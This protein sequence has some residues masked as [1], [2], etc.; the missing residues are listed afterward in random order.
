MIRA[1]IH[2]GL[3][4]LLFTIA[5][6]AV[7]QQRGGGQPGGTL[8]GKV[9]DSA[10]G[11]PLRV[12]TVSILSASDSVL[13]T[14]ALTERDG[15]FSITGMRPGRYYARVSYLGYAPR[16]ID[17]VVVTA[18]PSPI[19]LGAIALV[20]GAIKGQ[21]VSVTAQ[22]DFMTVEIDRTSYRAAD[23]P[24]AAGGSATDVLRNIPSIE[25]DVDGSVSL[26]GN[27]NVVVLLNGRALT[28]SGEALTSFLQNL[29]ANSIDRI[30][31]IPN[32]SAKYDPEGMSGIINIVLKEQGSRGLSGGVNAGAGTQDS[33]SAGVNLAYGNGAWN[34]YG[35]YGVNAGSRSFLG[36]REQEWRHSSRADQLQQSSSDS[37]S[38]IGQVLNASAELSIAPQHSLSLNTILSRRNDESGGASRYS[39]QSN[40]SPSRRYD[41]TNASENVGFGMDYRLGYK[42][43]TEASKHELSVETRYTRNIDERTTGYSQMSRALDETPISDSVAYQNVRQ[44]DGSWTASLQ[45]D[46][47][48]PVGDGGRVESGYLGERERIDGDFF[49]ERLDRTTETYRPDIALNNR[50]TYDREFHA[51]YGIYAHDFGTFGAQVGARVEQ[52]MTTFALLTIDSAYDNDYFSVFPSAYVTYKPSDAVYVKASYSRRINRPWTDILNP[53]VSQDD[54]TFSEIGNPL[55]KPEYI[56]AVELSLSH[57]TDATSLTLTPYY[58]RT[59]D[60]IRRY[61]SI[62]SNG[63]GTV[64]FKNFDNSVSLGTD[65]VASLRLGERYNIFA[66]FSLFQMTTDASNVEEGLGSDAF[67]WNGRL[68]AT[69]GLLP[70]M[71]MQLTYFYR[72]PWM[73]EGGGAVAAMQSGDIALTQKLLD[74]RLRIGLRVSDVL[75]QRRFSVTRNA[76]DF[77]ISF[78]RKPSSRAAMLTASYTFGTPERRRPTPQSSGE[79]DRGS[80]GW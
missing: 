67:G 21:E 75:D 53:F 54:P 18:A 10:S 65:I 13:V 12:A 14:G 39:E 48:R 79:P 55:I 57:F 34:L 16:I 9:I 8:V 28:M 69:L 77:D 30:E 47:V 62:D 63:V 45:L 43:V 22:R 2:P 72:A 58:R 73:L 60:V 4:V 42:W 17:H 70:G 38:W 5:L 61:G 7:A 51:V 1:S 76:D 11:E 23:M 80:G 78:W 56:D 33:Y 44:H 52:A 27:Q 3:L 36:E 49:S 32:P 6:P 46:Y 19:R 15:S 64:T 66:S 68:N 71:D 35:N 74:N 37:S 26:R 29:P 40:G 24:V 31:V 50:F 59:T 41:R 20:P 25:V